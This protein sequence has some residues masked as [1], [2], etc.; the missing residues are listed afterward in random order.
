MYHPFRDEADYALAHY[1]ARTRQSKT[2][3]NSYLN[4]PRISTGPQRPSFRNADEW[5]ALL[6]AIPSGIPDEEWTVENFRIKGEVEGVQRREYSIYFRDIERVIRFLMGHR[7]FMDNLT[8]APVRRYGNSDARIYTELYTADWW[9][10]TQDKLPEG[11]TLIPLL[12]SSDKTV[13]T[14]HHGDKAGWPVY[15]TI[16]NL[17]AEARRKETRPGTVLLGLIPITDEDH[18]GVKAEVYHTSMGLM[19][20][21][22]SGLSST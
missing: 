13:L 5:R 10:E 21:R 1:F 20:K 15:L 11:A 19:L 3:I 2:S 16:G 7:P 8:Y 12:L 9:W 17:D 4:D 22:K 14:Q 18:D 6:E